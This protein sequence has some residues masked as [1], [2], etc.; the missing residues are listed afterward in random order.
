M[1]SSVARPDSA[2]VPVILNSDMFV[3]RE[4]VVDI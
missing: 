2:S 1:V 3:P 4:R